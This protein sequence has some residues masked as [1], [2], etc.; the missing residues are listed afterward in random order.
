MLLPWWVGEHCTGQS[1]ETI[2]FIVQGNIYPSKTPLWPT[3]SRAPCVSLA[4]SLGA[5]PTPLDVGSASAERN[6]TTTVSIVN[7]QAVRVANLER[8]RASHACTRWRTAITDASV[9]AILHTL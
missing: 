6:P 1:R 8:K 5:P 2:G 7:V 3:A 4:Q 9:I